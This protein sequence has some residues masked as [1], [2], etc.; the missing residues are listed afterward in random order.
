MA[1]LYRK[2]SLEKL[3]NPDQLDQMIKISSPLSW[4]ALLS[5]L[6]IIIATVVWAFVG[7]LPTTETVN[8][9]ITGADSSCAVFAESAGVIDK[10]YKQSGDVVTVGEAIADV[11]Q[12]DGTSD[13]IYAGV[14]GK[15]SCTLFEEGASVYAGTEIARITPSNMGDQL[16][17]C[18]V[19]LTS[20]MKYEEGMV[21]KVYPSSVDYQQ[22]GHMQASVEYVEEYDPI[23]LLLRTIQAAIICWR[24][25]LC[26]QGL[27]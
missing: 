17:V 24:S 18:Y 27:L 6:L 12:G 21:V 11:M 8:G 3:S 22:Y 25:S 19:P 14:D 9:I 7:T 26:L 15:L 13:T 4:L 23:L 1:D 20:S 16:L 5:V 2:S 10:Y